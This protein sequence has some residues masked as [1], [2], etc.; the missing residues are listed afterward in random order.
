MVPWP[1]SAVRITRARPV[2][3]RATVF[4]EN[5][6]RNYWGGGGAL[7][8]EP[9]LQR[10][11]R[12]ACPPSRRRR[13]ASVSCSLLGTSGRVCHRSPRGRLSDKEGRGRTHDRGPRRLLGRPR[14]RLPSGDS[15]PR[16]LRCRDARSGESA[17]LVTVCN[18][19]LLRWYPGPTICLTFCAV[20]IDISPEFQHKASLQG[21]GVSVAPPGSQRNDPQRNNVVQATGASR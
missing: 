14:G 18:S 3:C 20:N 16:H 9:R 7:L 1:G 5:P 13:A 17:L 12:S 4:K 11:P 8:I 6:L 2:M 19:P 15:G 10:G 21:G